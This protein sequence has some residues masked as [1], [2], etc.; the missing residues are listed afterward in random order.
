M[1]QMSHDAGWIEVI[2]GCMYSG[3]TEELTRRVRR[4]QYAKQ[5]IRVF[6][7]T[8]DRGGVALGLQG[9]G[10]GGDANL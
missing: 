9:R 6:K 8:V 3:K 7:P 10:D 5:P 2:T 1:F 4:A